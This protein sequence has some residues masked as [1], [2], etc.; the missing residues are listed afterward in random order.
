VSDPSEV[1]EELKAARTEVAQSQGAFLSDELAGV[2]RS[3][4]LFQGN[5]REFAAF[6]G[7]F[8]TDATARVELW[9]LKNRKGFDAFLDEVDRLLHNYLAA[10][11]TLRNHTRR[12]WQQHPPAD[13]AL[14]A[15]Y[16]ERMKDAFAESPLVQFVQGL[17]NYATHSQLPVARGRLTWTPDAGDHSTVEL[18]KSKL[19]ESDR[20]N[21]AAKEFL[22]S[23]A[24]QIDLRI[25]VSAY[26]AVVEEFNEWFTRAFVTGHRPAFDDLNARK[27]HFDELLRRSGLPEA[28]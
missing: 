7:R 6:L 15:E 27:A 20:W 23:A 11:S 8:D 28:R 14:I 1:L 18:S 5:A 16:E 3:Y 21:T 22:D 26:T 10:A 19:L 4:W 9:A 2:A 12:L 17:R 24:E 13:P 25:L